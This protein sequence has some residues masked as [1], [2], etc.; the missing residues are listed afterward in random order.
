MAEL[1]ELSA[2]LKLETEAFEQSVRSAVELAAQMQTRL[3]INAQ[4]AAALTSQI[5]SGM[6]IVT[7]NMA[8]LTGRIDSGMRDSAQ[9]ISVLMASVTVGLTDA[10]TAVE[11]LAGQVRT[12]LD[13][14]AN[15]AASSMAA[16]ESA[17][18]GTWSRIAAAIQRAIDQTNAFLGMKGSQQITVQASVT[19]QEQ[20]L[21]SMTTGKSLVNE[22][23]KKTGASVSG[24]LAAALSGVSVVMD[25]RVVGALVASEVDREL[26]QL[27]QTR[28]YTG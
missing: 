6:A 22:G 23:S 13:S 17:A 26:G 27:A 25:G 3:E 15:S 11:S 14:T 12:H 4:S 5:A 28:R 7:Q 19:R 8:A 18:T 2:A 1:F 21:P 20:V 16:V 24:E 10:G 9:R